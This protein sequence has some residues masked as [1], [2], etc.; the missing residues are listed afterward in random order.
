MTPECAEFFVGSSHLLHHP[1]LYITRGLVALLDESPLGKDA[2]SLLV[3]LSAHPYE[4]ICV[5]AIGGMLRSWNR[6]PEVAWSALDL[7]VSLAMTEHHP[8]TISEEEKER[9]SRARISLLI[10]KALHWVNS[11]E[12]EP[13]EL[14]QMPPAWVPVADGAPLKRMVRGRVITAEWDYPSVEPNTDWLGKILSYIPLEAALSDLQRKQLLLAWCDDLVLWTIER[15]YPSWAI[16]EGR[17]NREEKASDLFVWRRCLFGFLGKLSLFI[18]TAESSGRFIEPAAATSDKIFTSLM[19]S[20]QE[21]L[22]CSLL[23]EAELSDVPLTLLRLIVSRMIACESFRYSGRYGSL[24]DSDLSTMVR[25]VFFVEIENAGGAARFANGD[26]REL[27][28]V[29]DVTAPF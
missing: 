26:W 27:P 18:S 19:V 28:A 16:K 24:S 17:P 25:E 22:I 14:P 13:K 23:D 10:S 5:E 3:R 9:L 15:V 11:S 7:A 29:F 1:V 4:Q 20:Y 12:R 6:L 2:H 21:S 8:F